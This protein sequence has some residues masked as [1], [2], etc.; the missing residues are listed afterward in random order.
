M[1]TGTLRLALLSLVALIAVAAGTTVNAQSVT[2]EDV[3]SIFSGTT[4]DDVLAAG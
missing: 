2:S 1:R 3:R 4:I